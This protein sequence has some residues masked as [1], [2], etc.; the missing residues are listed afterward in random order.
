M[1]DIQAFRGLRY[2]LSKVGSLSDVVAPPYDVI[3]VEQRSSLEA[4]NPHNI[5]RLILPG[6]EDLREGE[7]VYGLAANEL[8][9]WCRDR[10]LRPDPVA[11]VYV[12]HQCFEFEG[13]QYERRGF[14]ARV[15]LEPFGEGT[16]YP[17]E[18]THSKAKEDRYQ[19]MSHCRANLSPIFGI[20]PDAENRAQEILESAI[21]DRTPLVATDDGVEHRMW[22]VTDVDAISS[23][24]TV[25]GGLPVYIADGHHRYETSCRI[26]DESR[27]AGESGSA[28]YAMMMFI[29][30]HDPGLAVL[31]T[32]RLFRGLKAMT[33]TELTEKID[34][35]FDVEVVGTGAELC[36][37][38]WQSIQIEDQQ[39]TLGLYCAADDTWLLARL[40]VDGLAMMEKLAPDQSDRWRGLGVS[41]LHRLLVEELIG[42]KDLPA[43][44]YVHAIDEVLDGIKNGDSAGRDAT[45][46]TGTGA[47]FEL[48]A[49]VMPASVEDVKQ[50]SEQG[51]RMPA[52]STYF[53]PKLLSGLVINPLDD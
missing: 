35:A 11:S 36:E 39:T 46:Q 3:S 1:A 16:I 27:R 31:P 5:V 47:A 20:Y 33:S 22:K 7:S 6:D 42:E 29:S 25:L 43:P 19:L 9:A 30:M 13:R 32:H 41:L 28:D 38:V 51:L 49:L 48:V 52:K 45:G 34:R 10:I 8:K 15:K 40:S 4:R 50:I 44:K 14:L 21:E 26:R 12:Y 18:Q 24:A 23:A 2:D 17:H 53:F 37:D